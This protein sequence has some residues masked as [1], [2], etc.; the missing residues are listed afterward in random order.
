MRLVVV[1]VRPAQVEMVRQALAGVH[2]T[3]LTVCDTQGYDPAIAPGQVV[4]Q[5]VLEIAVNDDF[6][7][8]T[9]D[10]LMSALALHAEDVGTRLFV[11]PIDEAVQI[12]RDVRGPEAV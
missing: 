7:E 5:T 11:L 8:R 10:T 1:V 4:Q 2:V 3:R 12:Y 6:V 9:V